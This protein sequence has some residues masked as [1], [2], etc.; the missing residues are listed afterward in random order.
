M[1]RLKQAYNRLKYGAT[2]R[3]FTA[4]VTYTVI[5]NSTSKKQFVSGIQDTI[6]LAGQVF[7]RNGYPVANRD[8]Y[9]P[10]IK[11]RGL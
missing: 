3:G 6:K 9:E 5:A 4:E 1:K 11:I 7:E 8:G 10:R 2:M